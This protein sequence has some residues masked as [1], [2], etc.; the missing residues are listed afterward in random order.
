[1]SKIQTV[2]LNLPYT[3]NDKEKT[4]LRDEDLVLLAKEIVSPNTRALICM[5]IPWAI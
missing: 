5:H 4:I 1:M 2:W 3:D